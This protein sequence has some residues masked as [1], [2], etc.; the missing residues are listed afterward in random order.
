MMNCAQQWQAGRGP[1]RLPHRA[2]SRPGNLRRLWKLSKRSVRGMGSQLPPF[3][4][5]PL[6]QVALSCTGLHWVAL[7]LKGAWPP[8]PKVPVSVRL[9]VL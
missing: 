4:V 8:A 7:I 6:H 2:P 1:L 9:S 3:P 5:V